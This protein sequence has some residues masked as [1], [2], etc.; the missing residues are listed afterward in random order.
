MLPFVYLALPICSYLHRNKSPNRDI[1]RQWFWRNA[2]GLESFNNSSDVYRFCEGFFRNME[3]REE[4]EIPPL[5][6]SR[7]RL[8]QASYYY[9]SAISRAV[10]AFLANQKPVDFSDPHAEVLDNVYLQLS[11]APNLHHMYP[12][13]F[14]KG[15]TDLPK[16]VSP[17][18]LMNICYLRAKT[19]I[20]ISDKNPLEYFKDYENVRDFDAILQSHLIPT[21][22]I[23]RDGF[24]PTDYRDFLFARADLFAG[25][26]REALPDVD[27]QITD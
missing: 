24:E 14:L 9:R 10:L 13:N 1:A 12:Q 5:V 22:F 23:Q 4:P 2:F 19:N 6:L 7:T 11:Q 16:D 8:V 26:L 27:V 25:R 18:S 17:D 15:K 3:A 20:Q 21:E